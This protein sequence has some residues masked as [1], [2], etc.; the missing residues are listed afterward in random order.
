MFCTNMTNII[1]GKKDEELHTFNLNDLTRH[2]TILGS[3]GSGKTVF[4]KV[5]VE[6]CLK[7]KIPVIAIDPKG[8]LGGLG[9]YDENY[10]FRPYATKEEAHIQQV[11][12]KRLLKSVGMKKESRQFSH[13]TNIYTPKGEAGLKISLAPNL[14][15]PDVFEKEGNEAAKATLV[16]S[17]SDQI[18][19]LTNLGK[20][21][22]KAHS[23]IATIIAQ[24]WENNEDLTIEE[25]VSSVQKP[26]FERVGNMKLNDFISERKRKKVAGE[27]NLLLSK[28]SNQLLSEG[29]ALSPDMLFKKNTLS[30]FD[31]RSCFGEEEKQV[32]AEKVF[33]E[34]YKFLTQQKGSNSLKYVLYIDELASFLPPPPNKPASKKILETLIRQGRAFGLGIILATQNPGD[35]DYKVLGNIGNR[36]I[37]KVRS[38]NDIDKVATALDMDKS[39]LRKEIKSLATGWFVHNNAINNEVSIFKSRWVHTLHKGPLSDEEIT[40]VNKPKTKPNRKGSIDFEPKQVTINAQE[41]VKEVE[42]KPQKTTQQD[43][44]SEVQTDL[45]ILIQKVKKYSDETHIKI[46][47]SNQK[48]Y[49][50]HLRIIINPHKFKGVTFEKQGPYIFNLTTTLKEVGKE[51]IKNKNWSQYVSSDTQIED[52]RKGFKKAFTKSFRQARRNIK[53]KVYISNLTEKA[54]KDKEK[55]LEES[56]DFIQ[57]DIEKEY[58][59]LDEKMRGELQNIRKKINTNNDRIWDV[60]KKLHW[61]NIKRGFQRLILNKDL[62]KKTK[63]MKYYEKRIKEYKKENKKYRNNKIKIRE[64]YQ[65]QKQKTKDKYFKK[66]R[67]SVKTKTYTPQKKDV[68]FHST[69]LLLPKKP[70][71]R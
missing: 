64:K 46:S 33:Q 61:K 65:K 32:V 68:T 47:L 37:G 56:Y 34:I 60:Q 48:V 54:Y 45:E 16:D 57:K 20:E 25:L 63:K 39:S 15:K 28:P 22:E 44:K 50:P 29:K 53:Q 11:Q 5:L 59:L 17:V 7:R 41:L 3:T 51:V 23:L 43:V 49:T 4:G 69:I 35:I 40:W 21:K 30:V 66:A 12:S 18:I 55:A 42:K 24:R 13:T 6:E 26:D 27:I 10:D 52:T 36:F 19:N 31:L 62:M 14:D 70:S 71:K 1:L 58:D 67:Q 8:D 9:I 2:A 38:Q